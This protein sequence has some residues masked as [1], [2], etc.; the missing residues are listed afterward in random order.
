MANNVGLT[1][2]HRLNLAN[3]MYRKHGRA[4]VNK[5]DTPV[6]FR[7]DGLVLMKST[8]DYLG[9][10]LGG[11][12]IAIEAKATGGATSFPISSIQ[13]HQAAYLQAVDNAGGLALVAVWPYNLMDNRCYLLAYS[14]IVD[15]IQKTGRKSIKFADLDMDQHSVPID[16]YLCWLVEDIRL[17][18]Q[19][20]DWKI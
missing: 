15:Y 2:E 20:K 5:I 11:Q 16:D 8:V 19:F 6:Q 17:E 12:F 10:L 4:V 9:C 1:F 14:F 7:R 13:E 3:Q 18:E